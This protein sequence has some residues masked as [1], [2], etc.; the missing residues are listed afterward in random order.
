MTNALAAFAA[1]SDLAH[2]LRTAATERAAAASQKGIKG[3]MTGRSD[4]FRV[5]PFDIDVVDGFNLRSFDSAEVQEDLIHLAQDI[6]ARGVQQP[7]KVRLDTRDNRLK[8]VDGERRLRG[9]I[10]AIN[11]L[12]AADLTEVPVVLVRGKSD[13]DLIAEQFASNTDDLR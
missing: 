5:N 9:T 6:K 4:M 12:D 8:L 10:Y 1:T 2:A 7:L 11:F 3:I 13:A